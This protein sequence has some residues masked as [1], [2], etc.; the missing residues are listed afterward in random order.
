[1]LYSLFLLKGD[2]MKGKFFGIGVGVGD[3]DLISYKAVKTLE[4]IDYIDEKNYNF[5]YGDSDLAMRLNIE[6][7]KTIT[8]KNKSK[9]L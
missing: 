9:E 7:W 6:G 1:M 3:P 5:Y 2:R 4:K 8:L